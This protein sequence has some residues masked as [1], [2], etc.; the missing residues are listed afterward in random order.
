MDQIQA[1]LTPTVDGASSF[2][3]KTGTQALSGIAFM[4]VDLVFGIDAIEAARDNANRAAGSSSLS[5][6]FVPPP[7]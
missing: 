1:L 5:S 3:L 7:T 4:F 2:N 6:T